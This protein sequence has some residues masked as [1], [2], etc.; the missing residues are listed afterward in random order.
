MIQYHCSVLRYRT[1]PRKF[2]PSTTPVTVLPNPTLTNEFTQ[3][4][5]QLFLEHVEKIVTSNSISLEITKAAINNILSQT[6]TYL[7][8]VSVPPQ[9]LTEIYYKFLAENHMT[10]HTPLP[11]LQAKLQMLETLT[12]P[13]SN[14]SSS[15][16]KTVC[17]T[18]NTTVEYKNQ[19]P[20][21][22]YF[23]S[24]SNLY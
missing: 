10:N 5:E 6:E 18:N 2:R 8:S 23:Q 15:T 14:S 9:I 20:Q 11:V 7:S 22:K 16:T 19:P 13:I 21:D 24:C 12:P 4:Y 1:I 17:R 3:K